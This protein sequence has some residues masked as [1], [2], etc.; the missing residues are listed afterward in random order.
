MLMIQT[1]TF[2]PFFENTYV[3]YD[4]TNECIIIDPGCYTNEEQARLKEFITSHR[5]QPVR[6][7][8]THCHI[9][10]IL[11]NKFVYDTY[12]LKPEYHKDEQIV[13]N[14]MEQVSRMY[15]IQMDPSPEAARFI[16]PGEVIL[17]GHSGLLTLYTPGHS[18]AS[19]TLYSEKDKVCISG[20]VLFQGSIGRTDLPGGNYDKLIHS[21]ETQL[22]GLPDITIVYPG[23][24]DTTTIGF[25]RL[26]NPFLR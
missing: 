4:E 23:H 1:F 3:V 21:I 5:L 18:P 20:D 7:I 10:H 25:E 8:S 6:L 13:M 12:G 2:N 14:S 9:D 17:F 19:I 16:E 11:G 24:G 26:H 15:E 22:M